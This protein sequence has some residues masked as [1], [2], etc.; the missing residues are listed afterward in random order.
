MVA[1]ADFGCFYFCGGNFVAFLII[2][3]DFLMK[4]RG[5]QKNQIFFLDKAYKKAYQY[6]CFQK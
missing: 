6:A 2:L 4:L 3:A 1:L 5:L